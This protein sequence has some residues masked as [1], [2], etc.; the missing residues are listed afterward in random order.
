MVSGFGVS[1]FAEKNIEAISKN[2]VLHVTFLPVP[3][4]TSYPMKFEKTKV[5]GLTNDPNKVG[6]RFQLDFGVFSNLVPS[7]DFVFDK[8]TGHVVFFQG[9]SNI[10]NPSGSR[11]NVW[12]TYTYS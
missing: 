5:K 4:M 12:I 9:P 6:V 11:P 10:V 2:E 8:K 7:V 3:R 1:E